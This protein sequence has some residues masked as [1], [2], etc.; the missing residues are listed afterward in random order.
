M[1]LD[2]AGWHTAHD[3]RLPPSMQLLFLPPYSPELNPAEHVWDHI[4][5]NYFGNHV[6]T[7]LDAVEDRLCQAFRALAAQPE[8]VKSMTNFEWINTLCKT[9]N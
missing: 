4:R 1:I 8:I 7:S 2:G 3:L 5:E 6:F 9:A